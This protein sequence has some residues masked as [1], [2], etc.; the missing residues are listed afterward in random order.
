MGLPSEQNPHAPLSLR[1]ISVVH[2]IFD[3]PSYNRGY[4]NWCP[5]KTFTD[6]IVALDH[7]KNPAKAEIQHSLFYTPLRELQRSTLLNENDCKSLAARVLADPKSCCPNSR[8]PRGMRIYRRGHPMFMACRPIH[9]I[10]LPLLTPWTAFF[11]QRDS[12]GPESTTSEAIRLSRPAWS[13]SNSSSPEE[14]ARE[15]YGESLASS[16]R[17]KCSAWRGL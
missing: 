10:A 11:R 17:V 5:G 16:S 1:A 9:K 13:G 14:P 3:N 7:P 4:D 8:R 2:V 12:G 15:T 6:F